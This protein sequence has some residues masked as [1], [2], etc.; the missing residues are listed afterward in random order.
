M[1]EKSDFGALNWVKDELDHTISQAR[2]VLEAYAG[3]QV[4]L[5]SIQ[6]CAD[7]LHQLAGVLRM[8]Q[9]YGPVMLVEEMEAVALSLAEGE[10]AH[11]NEAVD[12]L[13][14]ALLQLPAYLE[15]IKAGERDLPLIILPL[16]NDLRAVRDV[17]LL[18]EVS[19]FK[20]ELG[21]I[22]LPQ[23]ISGEPN[24][25]VSEELPGLRKKYHFG[26][27]EWL[28]R[29]RPE[30]GWRYILSVFDRL[31]TLAGTGRTYQLASVC[32]ALTTGL[33]LYKIDPGVAVKQLFSQVDRQL[34]RLLDEG[35][36]GLENDQ[37]D[38][39][40][41]NLLYYIAQVDTDQPKIVSVKSQ[42]QLNAA[43]PEQ[44]AVDRGRKWLSGSNLELA[45]SLSDAIKA[46]LVRV[47]DEL[48]LMLRQTDKDPERL[49]QLLE[50]MGK[51]ADTL[52]VIGQGGLRNKLIA[53]IDSLKQSLNKN[54]F[55]EEQGLMDFAEDLI[56]IEACLVPQTALEQDA[57]ESPQDQGTLPEGEFQQ[58][59]KRT[60][61]EA[62]EEIQAIKDEI[63]DASLSQSG[64]DDKAVTAHF[65]HVSGALKLLEYNELAEI[66]DAAA[67][68][69]KEHAAQLSISEGSTQLNLLAELIS[70]IEYFLESIIDGA[71]DQQEITL[72][73]RMS[74]EQLRET[75]AESPES[76]STMSL[77]ST[78][79]LTDLSQT[80]EMSIDSTGA[81]QQ[82][83]DPTPAIDA[84]IEAEEIDPE[85]LEVF[86]EEAQEAM[87]TLS[88]DIPAW[89][90]NKDN[91]DTLVRFRRAFHSLK[92]SG[93]LV[94]A[95]VV[96]DTAWSIENMLNRL[97]DNKI[98]PSDE[99]D[100]L[101]QDSLEILPDLISALQENRPPLVDA[102]ALQE[103]AT[104]LAEGQAVSAD[105]A[106]HAADRTEMDV[107]ADET[108]QTEMDES[109]VPADGFEAEI[110]GLDDDQFGIEVDYDTELTVDADPELLA[111]F[112]QE[113]A[114][115]LEILD[116]YLSAA[117]DQPQAPDIPEEVARASHTLHGSA[118]MA[119][120]DHI[121]RLSKAIELFLKQHATQPDPQT[122][123]LLSEAVNQL[124]QELADLTAGQSDDVRI[125]EVIYRLN[126]HT[127]EPNETAEEVIEIDAPEDVAEQDQPDAAA[128]SSRLH[129]PADI[130]SSAS[131]LDVSGDDE[132]TEVFIEEARGLADELETSYFAWTAQGAPAQSTDLKRLL[133]TFK[134]SARLAGITPIGDLCHAME[135][136]LVKQ[137]EAQQPMSDDNLQLIRQSLDL[138]STQVDSV[139]DTGQVMQVDQWIRYLEQGPDEQTPI[140]S[141]AIP[142]EDEE[143]STLEQDSEHLTVEL[144]TESLDL[145]GADKSVA[146]GDDPELIEV[147][148]E[149]A[150]ALSEQ[151]E[152]AYQR[153]NQSPA[154]QSL[155]DDLKRSLHT[156]KGSARLS[157]AS[158]VG[159]LCH[160][161]ES[162]FGRIS[163]Q[164]SV[165]DQEK[166]IA[167]QAMD[168]LAGQIEEITQT[169]RVTPATETITELGQKAPETDDGDASESTE[170][171]VQ[172]KEPSVVLPFVSEISKKTEQQQVQAGFK[173]SKDQ[174]RINAE[175]MDNLVNHA[176]EISIYRARLEQQNN[177]L[178]FNL[179]ELE[180]TVTRL[181]NQLRQFEIETE[182]QIL[183]RWDRD[184]E[185]PDE[186]K[187]E[188]DPLE[189]DRFSTMQQLSR[190][191][192][193]TVTD[194][195]NLN[196][197]MLDLK[198]E[199]DT[200]LLQQSRISTDLQ[201]GLMRTRM[202][203]FQ[204]LVPRMQR[205]VR[206]TAQQ[207]GKEAELSYR[208]GADSELDRNILNRMV[209]AL[210]HLLR[211]S[212][213]HGIETI[214]EREKAGKTP[215]GNISLTIDREATDVLINLSD[216]GKGL[217]AKAIRKKA[218]EQGLVKPEDDLHDEDLFQHV[219]NPGFSTAKEVTQISGRGVGMDVVSSEVK[220][221]GGNVDISSKPGEGVKVAIRLPLTLAITDALLLKAGDE[222]YAIPHGSVEAVIRIHRRDLQAALREPEP[223]YNYAGIDYRL[224]DLSKMIGVYT[225]DSVEATRWS[226]LLLVHSGKHH[227][228]IQVDELLGTRQVVVKS[229]GSQIGSVRWIT[230]GTILADGTVALILDL[231]ALVRLE[232]TRKSAVEE[233]APEPQ[234]KLETDKRM[235]VMVVDDSITVRKVTGRLLER[236]NM[237]V[238]SAK[239]G[240]EAIA[241]LQE[242]VPDVMLLDIEMPRMDGFEVARHINNSVE[243]FG[244][245]II[246]ITSRAGDKHRQRAMEFG[247]KRYLGKPYQES[248]LIETIK[249]V[250]AESSG[251][252][253][254]E[255]TA[256]T[257]GKE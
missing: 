2:L 57:D 43:T 225:P 3:N 253:F 38:D 29:Q 34:K 198:R 86:I 97:I 186:D 64:M 246:M 194:L 137:D 193:E 224:K 237:E 9:V 170:A 95:M 89:I 227:M 11:A 45:E 220:Q 240:V 173:S 206:Q 50:P 195:G 158:P 55:P 222:H 190:S 199:T 109:V 118:N 80:L 125:E 58:M 239:D 148:L 255:T 177:V 192:I 241:L 12:V 147:F 161:L 231:H 77:D 256:V 141:I 230:G 113:S 22:E 69:F 212:V 235:Q 101:L 119:G 175:L 4:D 91:A 143:P 133:H 19:F 229:I 92:G 54:T 18:S 151:M 61:A 74:L 245:P 155:S 104:A 217:D 107:A 233:K 72:I 205:L 144:P 16:L 40:L 242:Q 60:T 232:A 207:M 82:T 73:A 93:R 135:N 46:E 154:D 160:A 200:L 59:V 90:A 165:D 111:I 174:V 41:K 221:L 66:I 27:V 142:A 102:A 210:E 42:Y 145:D 201:D 115:N 178:G 114:V 156:L 13:S 236:H 252:I 244:L 78:Q 10:S 164:D 44:D 71:G 183:Y 103:R 96:G 116:H 134:G 24:Q 106:S 204:Q 81:V 14:Q 197:T 39:L 153:W 216:D 248:D 150:R 53:R 1:I 185:Q 228:A 70:S 168:I 15:K 215:K 48:D 136:M 88:N 110:K 188:F 47:K 247:V 218:I 63:L 243:Y 202:V 33:M 191:L 176:G 8:V 17:E 139:A 209:P 208:A 112:V 79:T 25:R 35:E 124:H 172:D 163:E 85:I 132:L 6:L 203:P 37:F 94:G 182:T 84:E 5:E 226:P 100:Q 257:G 171:G 51:L 52:G 87:E 138:L 149:E 83:G 7:Y 219:F 180:R 62:I 127:A 129:T 32:S 181:Y 157:G 166:D 123:N 189:L 122:I 238:I 169:G 26:L 251:R 99:M 196:E 65:V 250:V 21:Q 126:S 75:E 105:D 117:L 120:A 30:K 140:E 249:E 31:E 184:N 179:V 121:A 20:P 162:F 213:S 187:E 67:E 130:L 152:T 76:M 214:A 56:Y 159:D 108:T 128:E 234:L 23:Q 223:V 36:T 211:N 146:V 49:A 28:S 98:T 254:S 131:L 167:R 68:Y